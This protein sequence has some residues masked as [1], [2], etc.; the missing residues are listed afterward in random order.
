M[1]L[2]KGFQSIVCYWFESGPA[3]VD[4]QRVQNSQSCHLVA[5]VINIFRFVLWLIEMPSLQYLVSSTQKSCTS[6]WPIWPEDL[7]FSAGVSMYYIQYCSQYYIVHT[8]APF[9]SYDQ[10]H[11]TDDLLKAVQNWHGWI[12]HVLLC[13]R[14]TA[15]RWGLDH[16]SRI[17]IF[18]MNFL[19]ESEGFI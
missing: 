9:S 13:V 19:V 10:S 15:T 12:Y 7:C 18:L 1:F 2:Q 14:H 11:P 4:N 17:L 16:Q 3:V 8:A 5:D 6:T